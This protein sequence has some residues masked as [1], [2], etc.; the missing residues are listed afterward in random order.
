M[1]A[2]SQLRVLAGLLLLGIAPYGSIPGAEPEDELKSAIVLSI[3]RYSEFPRAVPDNTLTVLV[4]GRPSFAQVLRRVAEGKTVNGRQ[5]RVHDVKLGETARACQIYYVAADKSGAIKAALA[6][7]QALGA[8]SIGESDR[9]LDYGGAVNL[10]LID[11][12]MSFEVNMSVLD[13][14]GIEISSKLLR[15]GVV[16]RRRH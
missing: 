1:Q 11:G 8:L 15:F 16:T 7:A 9:F 5:I 13:E 3:L 10:L 6:E 14:S 4:F 12:R 2:S